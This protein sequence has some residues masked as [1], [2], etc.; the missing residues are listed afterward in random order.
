MKSSSLLSIF[1]VCSAVAGSA[2]AQSDDVSQFTTQDGT[3]VTVHSGQPT[4]PSYGPRPSFEQLDTDHDG[5][6]SRAEAQVYVPLF[7]DFDHLT[8][9]ERISKGQY[10]AWDYR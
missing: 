10:A 3:R 1:V 7:N 2:F 9:G 8:H 5:Y 4:A 6:I